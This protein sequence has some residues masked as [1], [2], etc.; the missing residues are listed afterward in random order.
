[1]DEIYNP[2]RRYKAFRPRQ[3]ARGVKSTGTPVNNSTVC[4]FNNTLGAQYLVVRDL[5]VNGN[6]SDLVAASYLLGQIGA[7]PGKVSQLI[8]SMGVQVGII[9][10]IDTA[11]VYPPDYDIALSSTGTWEWEHDFPFAILEPGWSLIFQDTTVA[12]GLQVSA[13]WESINPD[14]LDWSW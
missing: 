10:S 3:A 6:V 7:G 8:P 14:E 13:I 4:L 12:H 1:V 9:T 2:D 5:T 11:T